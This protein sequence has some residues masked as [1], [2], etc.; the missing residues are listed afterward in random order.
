MTIVISTIA[1]SYPT[2]IMFTNLALAM[3]TNYT[4]P[5]YIQYYSY[6]NHWYLDITRVTRCNIDIIID[7]HNVIDI[8][9]LVIGTSYILTLVMIIDKLYPIVVTLVI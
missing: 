7:T 1:S 4:Y 8:G 5:S 9:T 3:F 6:I 2:V